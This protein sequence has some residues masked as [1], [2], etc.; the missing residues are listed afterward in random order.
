MK[1]TSLAG[2]GS[3]AEAPGCGKGMLY[4]AYQAHCDIMGP[5]RA[6]AASAAGRLAGRFLPES[7]GTPALRNLTAAY[8]LIARAGLTHERPPFGID[9]VTVGNREVAVTEEPAHVTPFGTLLHFKKDIEQAQP[10]VLLIAPLSGHFATLLRSTVR[11]MLPEHDVYITDWH[12]VRDVPVEDGAFG[13]DDYVAP[14]DRVSRSAGAGHAHHRRV[15]ALRGRADRRRHHGAER[16]SRAP[17]EHDADGRADRHAGPSDQGEHAGAEQ[18][19]RVVREEPDRDGAAPLSR[20]RAPGLSGVRAA[21][22]VHE[23]EHRSPHQGA[24]R[25]LRPPRQGR[26]REGQGEEGFLRRI[27]RRARPEP[28]VLS[29]DGQAGFPG[30]CP[31]ARH[32]RVSWA[33]RSSPPRSV[34][35]CC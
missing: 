9:R 15:P 22:G 35:R 6:L 8:E 30:P 2:L 25:A 16:Q 1:C 7:V 3:G 11:T 24:S 5:V 17:A 12:N 29:R 28:G 13:F 34:A 21:R 33:R 14:P 32:D 20:R 4:Q 26:D 10:R 19:D 31:A 23:H 18:T 27:L